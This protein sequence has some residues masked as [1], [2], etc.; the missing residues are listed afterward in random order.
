MPS[1]LSVLYDLFVTGQRVRR[2][3]TDA[4]APSGMKPDEY[5][6][7]SVVV[8]RG[9]LTATQMSDLLGMPLSTVLDYLRSMG[10]A[11]HLE[12]IPHPNDGRAVQ[13]RLSPSGLKSFQRGHQYFE[14]AF[15][16][17]ARALSMP[18]ESVRIAIAAL[19]D[20]VRE[21]GGSAPASNPRAP[22]FVVKAIPPRGRKRSRPSR[23]RTT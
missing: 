22:R 7:Y 8:A 9:P 2:V 19:D 6:V 3:L 5:A 23:L 11:G 17:I 20:A 4:M 13:V 12:R 14:L 1:D 10:A 15:E 18:L 16:R 21:V